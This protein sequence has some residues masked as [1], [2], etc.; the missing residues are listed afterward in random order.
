[1]NKAY[2]L[3]K[4]KTLYL[5]KIFKKLFVKAKLYGVQNKWKGF[6]SQYFF[7]SITKETEKNFMVKYIQ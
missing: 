2:Y 3:F 4:F 7:S 5:F 1:M 6:S